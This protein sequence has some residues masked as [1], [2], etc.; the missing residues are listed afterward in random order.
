MTAIGRLVYR[1]KGLLRFSPRAESCPTSRSSAVIR[2]MDKTSG[3]G[4]LLEHTNVA[5]GIPQ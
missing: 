5:S 3:F 1:D 4:W 2:E